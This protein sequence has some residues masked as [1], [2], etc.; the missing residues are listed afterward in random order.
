MNALPIIMERRYGTEA[1]AEHEYDVAES[2]FNAAV[3]DF[4]ERTRLLSRTR[5]T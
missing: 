2:A 5:M 4:S 1:Q 3:Q